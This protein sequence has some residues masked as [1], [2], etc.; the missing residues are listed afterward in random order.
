MSDAQLESILDNGD[1]EDDNEDDRIYAGIEESKTSVDV[2]AA[3]GSESDDDDSDL[4]VDSDDE[5]HHKTLPV[6]APATTKPAATGAAPA[7]AKPGVTTPA[8]TAVPATATKPAAAASTTTST[9]TTT[10]RPADKKAVQLSAAWPEE[11][12]VTPHEGY[13][14][15]P[16]SQSGADEKG[17]Y[18]RVMPVRFREMRDDRLMNSLISKYAR[19]VRRDGHNTGD[20]FLNRDDA[21]DAVDEVLA[22]HP[23]QVATLNGKVDFDATWKHFDVNS[24]GLVE[25][26]R[27]PQ[28]LRYLTNGALNVDL[29]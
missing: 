26:G 9:T 21:Q 5:T 20:F 14:E 15:I 8:S 22:T 25:V 23:D 17:G 6:V 7:T 12:G 2:S 29:Q 28:F 1:S 18:A 19:E 13:E 27:F 24:D 11:A 3:S 16:A 10:A 4:E